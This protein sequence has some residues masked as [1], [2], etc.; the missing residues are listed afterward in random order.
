MVNPKK[1]ATEA[2]ELLYE[3]KADNIM[4]LDIA[5]LTSI[6]DYFVICSGRNTIQVRAL[7]DDLADKL[8]TDHSLP[9]RKEGYYDARWIVL[10]YA[11]VI[12]HIFHEQERE[13]YNIE[14][15]WMDGSNLVHLIEEV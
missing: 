10:D 5:H 9:L 11:S 2:A 14:R 8:K 7:A 15:L 4:V 3:K 13:Y 6:A 1:L 12:V